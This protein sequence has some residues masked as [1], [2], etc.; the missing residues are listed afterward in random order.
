MLLLVFQVVHETQDGR[1]PEADEYGFQ[2]FSLQE[3]NLRYHDYGQDDQKHYQVHP[4]EAFH[5]VFEHAS[6]IRLNIKIKC[7]EILRFS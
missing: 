5:K 7:S 1:G 6:V 3:T 4:A 2:F